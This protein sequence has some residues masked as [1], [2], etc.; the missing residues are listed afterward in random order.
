MNF[1]ELEKTKNREHIEETGGEMDYYLMT[2][3]HPEAEMRTIKKIRKFLTYNYHPDLAP[4]GRE[5]EYTNKMQN[6]LE[7]FDCLT[8]ETKRE[9]YN[10][11]HPYFDNI[12]SPDNSHVLG[13]KYKK[14]YETSI[15]PFLSSKTLFS[16][17]SKAKTNDSYSPFIRKHIYLIAKRIEANKQLTNWQRKTIPD[18]ITNAI[19]IG[20]L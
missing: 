1:A 17:A 14:E 7:A 6:I 11:A 20:L 12:K 4:K 9:Q 16:L 5:K 2:Q 19:E 15:Q 13:Y 8:D 18:V 10:K 3:V